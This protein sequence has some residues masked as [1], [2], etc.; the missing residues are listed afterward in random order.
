VNPDSQPQKCRKTGHR[1]RQCRRAAFVKARG[2]AKRRWEPQTRDDGVKPR[3]L[4]GVQPMQRPGKDPHR[5]AD[6]DG[7]MVRAFRIQAESQRPYD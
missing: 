4:N 6:A 1:F 5:R 7:H 2:Q 3:I